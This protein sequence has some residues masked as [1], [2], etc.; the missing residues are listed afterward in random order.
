VQVA[1]AA[2]SAHGAPAGGA[3]AAATVGALAGYDVRALPSAWPGNAAGTGIA[4]VETAACAATAGTAL[5]CREQTFDV[6]GVS[7]SFVDTLEN[8]NMAPAM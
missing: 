2:G 5:A 6:G 4:V 1:W 3:C 8:L 7:F